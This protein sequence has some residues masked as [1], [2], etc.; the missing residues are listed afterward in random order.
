M[1]KKKKKCLGC[2]EEKHP[3]AHVDGVL[4]RESKEQLEV[5]WPLFLY[6]TLYLDNRRAVEQWS[7]GFQSNSI[8]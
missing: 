2:I 4:A 8:P 5:W 6:L 1:E 3:R 7:G